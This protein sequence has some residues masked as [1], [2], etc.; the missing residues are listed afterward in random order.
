MREIDVAAALQ[1][2]NIVE[3]LDR[4]TSNGVVYLVT[5]FVDGPDAARLADEQGGKLPYPLAVAI[6]LQVLAALSHAHSQGFIHRDIKD[7]NILVGGSRIESGREAHRLRVGQEFY[8]IRNE[9]S[10][11]GR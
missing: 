5:E 1:H 9:R 4:G 8:P 2:P 10:D 6:V 11:D 3:F 7:Q